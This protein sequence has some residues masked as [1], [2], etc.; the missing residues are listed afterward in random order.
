MTTQSRQRVLVNGGRQR[1]GFS[2]SRHTLGLRLGFR[3]RVIRS[4]RRAPRQQPK[5]R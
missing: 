3:F 1:S 4:S 2:R 5:Y